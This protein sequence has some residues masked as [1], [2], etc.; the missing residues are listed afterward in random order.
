MGGDLIPAVDNVKT[1]EV[2]LAAQTAYHPFDDSSKHLITEN[3]ALG[4]ITDPVFGTTTADMYFNLSSLVYG[5]SPFI[6]KDSVEVIDSV[7]LSL[8]YR[9]AY[10]DTLSQIGVQVNEIAQNNNFNDTTLYRFDQP[11][12]TTT[13]SVLGTKTFNPK[14]LSDSIPFIR[15]GVTTKVAN[16]LRIRL[17]NSLGDKLKSFDTTGNGGYKNDSLFRAA[18]RGLVVTATTAS[19]PGALAYFNLVDNNDTR[20]IVYYR[21][22]KGGIKDTASASFIHS[23]YSQA[24]SVK[25]TAGGN[26]LAELNTTSP[27]NLYIQSSP[28]GSY[29]SIKIKGLDTLPNKVIHRA[30]LIAYKV[31]SLL[32]NIFTVPTRLLLD[33]KSSTNGKDTAYIFENDLQV[34]VDGSLNF[35]SFGGTLRSDNTY[36]YNL[37]RYVQGIVTRKE[38]NDS[39]RLYAPL[40]SNLF[41][42][43]LN[44]NI[45][46]PILPAIANG[47]VVLASGTFTDPAMRLRLHIIYSNL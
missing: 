1:F 42:K 25:R 29:V 46:I 6:N 15:A 26:Y 47:R 45:S 35:N 23:T 40:R 31:P 24:N 11:G 8:A 22:K 27:Q 36:R 28:L 43:N 41:A 19:G 33:H 44:Q 14:T 38:K 34:N 20:L 30:E 18:F 7:V 32:D 5:S 21:A 13:G 3:M 10:G 39:L 9:G 4:K 17:N 37:T 12:F 16:V 2:N